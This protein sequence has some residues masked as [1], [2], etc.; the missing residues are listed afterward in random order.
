VSAVDYDQALGRI[1]KGLR[2]KNLVDAV[3]LA[4]DLGKTFRENYARAERIARGPPG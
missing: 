1:T 3:S 4:R 2:S